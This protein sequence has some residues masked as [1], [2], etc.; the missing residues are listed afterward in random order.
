M[1]I[2]T[3]IGTKVE[4]SMYGE[5]DI[6]IDIFMATKEFKTLEGLCGTFGNNTTNDFKHYNSS[7]FTNTISQTPGSLF[8]PDTRLLE[9]PRHQAP[10]STQTPGSLFHPDNFP[11]SCK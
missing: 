4:I 2:L 5:R 7:F 9:P 10:C 11:S 8:H 6:N 3:P 1:Q